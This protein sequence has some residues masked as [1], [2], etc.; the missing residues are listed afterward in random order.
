M[1]APPLPFASLLRFGDL[2]LERYL[3][4]VA[5]GPPHAD[6]A[7]QPVARLADALG[8]AGLQHVATGR[9]AT[10]YKACSPTLQ[11]TLA[12]AL[13]HRAGPSRVTATAAQLARLAHP[14]VPRVHAA[15]TLPDGHAWSLREWIDGRSLADELAD[16]SVDGPSLLRRGCRAVGAAAEALHHANRRGAFHAAMHAEHVLVPADPEREAALIGWGG[17][18]HAPAG[19][20]TAVANLAAALASVL[21]ALLAAAAQ[22]PHSERLPRALRAGCQDVCDRART[23]RRFTLPYIAT[24]LRRALRQGDADGHGRL[25]D[26]GDRATNPPATR[27]AHDHPQ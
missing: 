13:A 9:E 10:L 7:S 21:H 3:P 26:L 20:T 11:R 8:L 23:S 5:A 1:S 22:R 6:A 19:A 24:A 14:A 18:N 12:L 25:D 2:P 27:G 4:R 16:P 15:G 17:A